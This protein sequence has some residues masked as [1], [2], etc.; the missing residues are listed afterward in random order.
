MIL[1]TYSSPTVMI[2]SYVCT[3][4][5]VSLCA[6]LLINTKIIVKPLFYFMQVPELSLYEFTNISAC[7][8]M[9]KYT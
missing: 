7:H 6:S 5:D 8:W 1:N 3:D 9:S 2:Q 4:I